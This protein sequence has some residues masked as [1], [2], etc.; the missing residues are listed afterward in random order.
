VLPTTAAAGI[1][2]T[3]TAIATDIVDGSV[4]VVCVPPSGSMFA[5]GTTRIAYSAMDAHRN[6]TSGTF[7][8]SVILVKSPAAHRV[9]RARRQFW[10]QGTEGRRDGFYV[11]T[12]AR[13]T[14]ATRASLSSGGFTLSNAE[15][16]RDAGK[17]GVTIVGCARGVRHF[18]GRYDQLQV[19]AV[20]DRGGVALVACAS[21][22]RSD[23]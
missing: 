17:T 1:V 11:V 7:M 3:F 13:G 23:R 9:V 20:D 16:H 5:V 19:V 18:R 4:A 10:W 15:D 22:R 2:H 8:V 21:S 6:L 14:G 12:A